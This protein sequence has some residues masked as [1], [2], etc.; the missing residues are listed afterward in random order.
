MRLGAP[1][2]RAES[3]TPAG[4][5]ELPPRPVVARWSERELQNAVVDV[6]R[7]LDWRTYHTFDSR[8]SS[9]GFPD[10][11]LVRG[12]RLVFAELKTSTG[13]VSQHQVLWLAS[14]SATTAETYVWRPEDWRDGS[15]ERVLR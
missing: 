5:H 2:D 7:L 14:L 13:V 15:I 10:L 4:G 12:S 11:T 6:A 3:R 8:R 9:P 1:I